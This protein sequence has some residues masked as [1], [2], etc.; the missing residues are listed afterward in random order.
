MDMFK[1]KTKIQTTLYN[2]L[3][4]QCYCAV[5]SFICYSVEYNAQMKIAKYYIPTENK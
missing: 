1:T 4:I 5:L 3:I 2:K